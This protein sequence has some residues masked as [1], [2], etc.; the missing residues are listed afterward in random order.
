MK[1]SKIPIRQI[2]ILNQIKESIRASLV[3]KW[4]KS[5]FSKKIL[6]QKEQEF[7]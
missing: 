7:K 5:Y 3:E 1:I 2:T 4:N 6:Q